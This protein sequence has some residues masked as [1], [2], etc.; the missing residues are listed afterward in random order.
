MNS[1]KLKRT[2]LLVTVIV[3]AFLVGLAIW[4]GLFWSVSTSSARTFEWD[5][6][7]ADL[8]VQLTTNG[9]LSAGNGIY[10]SSAKLYMMLPDKPTGNP[11][12]TIKGNVNTS[13]DMKFTLPP[14]QTE[15]GILYWAFSRPGKG[16]GEIVPAVD[17]RIGFRAHL[18]LT[19]NG[20]LWQGWSQYT[21]SPL[22]PL[23]VAL[24]V[25]PPSD[26]YTFLGL[27]ATT[28]AILI[29]AAI[30]VPSA[31]ESLRGMLVGKGR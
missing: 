23:D 25:S 8:Y 31:V 17:G 21:S 15:D 20:T 18:K 27:K 28:A 26:Y 14:L 1:E 30:A 16:A 13:G 5:E 4:I 3:I 2:S 9:P 12:I 29:A 7:R 19:L 6:V 11:E 10:I 24:E 22:E